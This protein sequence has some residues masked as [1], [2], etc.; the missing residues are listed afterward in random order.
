M[1]TQQQVLAYEPTGTKPGSWLKMKVVDD[2]GETRDAYI[3]DQSLIALVNK[4][5]IYEFKKEKNGKYWDIT[6]VKFVRPLGEAQPTSNGGTQ[7]PAAQGQPAR[8]VAI[9]PNVMVQNRAITSQVCVKA[10]AEIMGKLIEAGAFKDDKGTIDTVTVTDAAALMARVLM[11]EARAF[12]ISEKKP[13][14]KP[15]EPKTE[16]YTDDQGRVHER[17][18]GA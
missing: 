18:E 3:K 8:I 11:A 6:G 5:G 9:D 16:T 4:P 13:E 15:A 7:Q 10:A 1:T 17:V 12:V 14:P 2:K